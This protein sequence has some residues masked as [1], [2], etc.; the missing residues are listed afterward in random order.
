MKYTDK[1]QEALSQEVNNMPA[2]NHY[3]NNGNGPKT[4]TGIHC[5]VNGLCESLRNV[6]DYR[7]HILEQIKK[8]LRITSR[9][10]PR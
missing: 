10:E 2:I 8:R 7:L 6:R 1:Q 3:E 5:S 9:K 4:L